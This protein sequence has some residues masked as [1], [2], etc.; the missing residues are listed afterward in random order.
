MARC[1][2]AVLVGPMLM[3]SSLPPWI[4]TWPVVPG[5]AGVELVDDERDSARTVC[6]VLI[7]ISHEGDTAAATTGLTLS[8]PSLRTST[9]HKTHATT[10]RPTR[11]AVD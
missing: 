9:R 6:N 8:P 2:T 4:Q 1:V 10:T 5:T 7:H 3:F 11:A